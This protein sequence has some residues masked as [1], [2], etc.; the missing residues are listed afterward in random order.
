MVHITAA[1]PSHTRVVHPCIV[2]DLRRTH[3]EVIHAAVAA[4]VANSVLRPSTTHSGL[5]PSS[6]PSVD[7]DDDVAFSSPRS[8]SPRRACA[9][10][11][12]R[13]VLSVCAAAVAAREVASSRAAAFCDDEL[14][15]PQVRAPVKASPLL[16]AS[17]LK[18]PETGLV[19]GSVVH[20]LLLPELRRCCF[21]RGRQ[22]RRLTGNPFPESRSSEMGARHD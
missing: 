1:Y 8:V 3:V 6:G 14:G 22:C 20:A 17:P 9:R 10:R 7:V 21:G 4:S 15:N 11:R 18:L 5:L 19:A 16:S 13:R 12:R 2:V